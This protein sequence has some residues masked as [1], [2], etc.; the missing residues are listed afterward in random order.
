VNNSFDEKKRKLA[1]LL[2][3]KAWRMS[4]LYY[5]KDENG[6]EFKF[7]C[8]EAQQE[9][10]NETHP[11]NIILKA[12]QLGITTFYCINFLDDCLFNSN[13][14][15]VLIGDDLEDAK[16]LLRDK[17]RYAYDRLPPEIKEHRKLLTD[18]TE[19]MRFSNGSS[20]SVTTS[21]RSGTVQR[22]HI[23]EFGKICRKSPEK[24]EEIMSGSLNTVHQGQ[25][26]VIEST[27]QG[28]SG[29]FFNLCQVA[30]RKQRM[31]EELTLLD[32][33]FHFFGWWKDKKYQMDA[34]Y[35]FS[36]KQADYFAE[37]EVE[38]IKLIRQQQAWYCKKE[39]TQGEL[40]KQE[41]P[42]NSKEA[43]EKAIIGAYW[44]KELIKAEKDGKIGRVSVDGSLPVHT[45]WDIGLDDFTAI[46]F[47]QKKGFDYMLVDYYEWTDEPL[48]F[49]LKMLKEK[50]YNY[51]NH[52]LPH[53]IT[54]RAYHDGQNGLNT[55]KEFGFKFTR[56]ERTNDLIGDINNVRMFFPR[57]WFD[58]KKCELGLTRLRGY[59]KKFIESIG[60]FG[61]TP[62]KGVEN[63]CADAFRTMVASKG[64]LEQEAQNMNGFVD[65]WAYDEFMNASNRN[66]I[67]GY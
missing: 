40:M 64:R 26:I 56:I 15:A 27:A 49:Y 41:F 1:E 45:A 65:E 44:S 36:T 48:P 19:I 39:E 58:A 38:G 11:L 42:S 50:N 23:T 24:A 46:W 8:N 59:K 43:F 54:K 9:L 62:A 22:L 12:R 17:V 57:C 53:D 10:I 7:I 35:N 33:K 67:T 4:N 30:E 6:K 3:C 63:H 32:W 18:S 61:D 52:F 51:G 21:A 47:F 66:S 55:A 34:D 60:A 20:Y 16:K 31:K 14:T 5:C 37:L 28:A 13:I 25:Q 2:S 29:H